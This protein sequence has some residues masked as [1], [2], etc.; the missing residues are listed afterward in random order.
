MTQL[1]E[2]MYYN[3]IKPEVIGGLVGG[4]S[5]E[6]QHHPKLETKHMSPK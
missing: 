2:K 1:T 5:F 3:G 4:Q 6:K